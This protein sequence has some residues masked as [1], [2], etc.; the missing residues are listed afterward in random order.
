M[1]CEQYNHNW[2]KDFEGVA[3]FTCNKWA[4]VEYVDDLE[5]I[6]LAA[7]EYME[8]PNNAIARDNLIQAL[9]MMKETK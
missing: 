2:W 5:A 1:C 3:C 7:K 6:A 9:D 4:D 8:Q